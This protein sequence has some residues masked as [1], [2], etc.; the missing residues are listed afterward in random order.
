MDAFAL[1]L[2]PAKAGTAGLQ[3]LTYLGG[4]GLQVAYGIDFDANGNI[5]LAGFTSGQIFDAFGGPG[6]P[7]N[8]GNRDGY[9]IGFSS[10]STSSSSELPTEN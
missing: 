3:Y 8:H 4:P 2:N 7:S 1:K 10:G 5:Y 6:K 9:V